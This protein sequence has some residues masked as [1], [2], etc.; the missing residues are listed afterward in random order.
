MTFLGP[1]NQRRTLAGF[2]AIVFLVSPAIARAKE[3]EGLP[4]V[5][6]RVTFDAAYLRGH[7]RALDSSQSALRR[8]PVS[9]RR[10]ASQR[11]QPPAFR[12]HRKLQAIGAAFIG[13][14]LGFWAGA[15]I[16]GALDSG[17]GEDAGLRGLAIGAPIGAAAGAAF[18]YVLA[19]R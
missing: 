4:R 5:A 6:A 8:T 14:L 3:A 15:E 16:G 13:G 17:G 19:S 11:V 18:G 2:V 9:Q 12:P 7:V 1:R 10:L